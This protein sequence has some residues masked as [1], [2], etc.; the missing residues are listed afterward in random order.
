MMLSSPAQ[1]Q[2]PEVSAGKTTKLDSESSEVI[3]SQRYIYAGKQLNNIHR[4]LTKQMSLCSCR[5]LC[6]HVSMLVQT[7]K[8]YLRLCAHVRPPTLHDHFKHHPNKTHTTCACARAR[9]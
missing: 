7:C 5:A 4:I 2:E 1:A 6:L 8:P 9:P 3:K